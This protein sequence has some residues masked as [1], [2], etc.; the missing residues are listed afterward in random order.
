MK[1]KYFYRFQDVFCA[2]AMT[3]HFCKEQGLLTE[4]TVT[5]Q[6]W[7]STPNQAKRRAKASAKSIGNTNIECVSGHTQLVISRF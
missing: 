4:G 2:G 1:F 5:G 6:G 3:R 7:G